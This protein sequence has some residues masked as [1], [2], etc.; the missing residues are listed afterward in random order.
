[1]P[2]S[3]HTAAVIVEGGKVELRKIEVPKVGENEVLVNVVAAAL[4][5]VDCELRS[6]LIYILHS[7]RT[8][9]SAR[10]ITGPKTGHVLG[11]DFS[12]VVAELGPSAGSTGIKCESIHL[13]S[14]RLVG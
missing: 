14:T 5:P 10:G 11:F 8:G 12:G 1:M 9:K 7:C 2:A 3:T 4:N 13:L 6:H